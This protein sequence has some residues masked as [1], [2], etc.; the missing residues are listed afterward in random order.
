MKRAKNNWG[1]FLVLGLALATCNFQPLTT[2]LPEVACDRITFIKGQAV[3]LINPDGSERVRLAQLPGSFWL[4]DPW[5][6]SAWVEL[7]WSPDGTKL[8]FRALDS[9]KEPYLYIMNADG[10]S[11][12]PLTRTAHHFV[13]WAWTSDS[14]YIIYYNHGAFIMSFDFVTVFNAS[15]AQTVCDVRYTKGTPPGCSESELFGPDGKQ[16]PLPFNIVPR[17]YSERW[18]LSR[19][20]Y[21]ATLSPDRVWVVI[22]GYTLNGPDETIHITRSDGE[23][24]G[25][26][27][28]TVTISRDCRVERLNWSPDSQHFAF[29]DY[30]DGQVE[31]WVINT[32]DGSASL[33][34]EFAADSCPSIR[35]SHDGTHVGL[36]VASQKQFVVDW[37]D[38]Q[39][40]LME[41]APHSKYADWSSGTNH[42]LI[43]VSPHLSI[44]DADVHQTILPNGVF[45]ECRWSPNGVWL[46][47]Y[48][49][50]A[51]TIFNLTTDEQIALDLHSTLWSPNDRWIV[52]WRTDDEISIFDTNTHQSAEVS[53]RVD[54]F[55]WTP[56]CGTGVAPE[57][58]VP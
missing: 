55:V 58:E 45:D 13:G 19:G 24:S 38:E 33:L 34:A 50:D 31:L 14:Q 1:V 39:V 29:S 7:R 56:S 35:W 16:W 3:Y 36:T 11:L 49:G 46:A 23:P 27:P 43:S 8:A 9:H 12:T 2:G 54:Y 40:H 4:S 48:G 6:S 51:T 37:P 5:S 26:F 10:S 25:T 47:C 28:Q 41:Q 52:G 53:G 44:W 57:S 15:T 20:R 22:R 32:G 42:L 30:Q 17:E 18:G 21:T